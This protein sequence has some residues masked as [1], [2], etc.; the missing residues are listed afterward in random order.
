[1]AAHQPPAVPAIDSGMLPA[2]RPYKKAGS[3][4]G[5]CCYRDKVEAKLANMT[6]QRHQAEAALKTAEDDLHRVTEDR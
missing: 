3:E 5:G 1:M 6:E 2:C 4:H